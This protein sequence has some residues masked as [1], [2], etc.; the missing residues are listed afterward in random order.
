MKIAKDTVVTMD[1]ELRLDDDD[2]VVDV[3]DDGTFNFLVGHENI[4]PGLETEIIGLTAGE[5]RDIS[6]AAEDGYGAR[7][8]ARVFAVPRTIFPTDFYFEV[9]I[10]VDL[11]DED[12]ESHVV[13]VVGV[14]GDDVVLD[15]NHP[16]ADRTLKFRI[17]VKEV[18]AATAT[19]LEHGHVH[20]AHG[21]EH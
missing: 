1:Y 4:V 11:E 16:L 20:G 9:G 17:K 6:V 18:R 12:G 3:S 7:D 14:E 8:A 15:P 21:H 10:P 2:E 5:E 19:E 13:W